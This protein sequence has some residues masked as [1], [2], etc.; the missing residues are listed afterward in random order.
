MVKTK[1]IERTVD[2]Y[3]RRAS[4]A[5]PD[6][7]AGIASPK[8][9]QSSAAINAADVYFSAVSAPSTKELFIRGLKR[10]G[11]TKWAD[12]AKAKGAPRFISGVEAGQ[13]YYRS[14]MTD[15]LGHVEAT[16][17]P[18]RGPTGSEANYERA[19]KM[20]MANRAWKLASKTSIAAK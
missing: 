8:R 17:L 19:K 10:A 16:A 15:F 2:K 12:M 9:S 5:R 13:P 18:A 6:Y 3:A 7:E 20:S 1:G 4:V 11:D 14:Q